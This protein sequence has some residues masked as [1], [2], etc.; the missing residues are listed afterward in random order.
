MTTA[1]QQSPVAPTLSLDD[2]SELVDALEACLSLADDNVRGTILGLVRPEIVGQIM[3]APARRADIFNIVSTCLSYPDGLRELVAAIRTFEG[4]SLPMQHLDVLV[5]LLLGSRLLTGD[6]L[7]QLK[8]ILDDPTKPAEILPRIFR[9]SYGESLAAISSENSAATRARLLSILA[10][11]PKRVGGVFPVLEFAARLA[12][13]MP[14][15]AP[16]LDVWLDEAA[17]RL[18]VST[19]EIDRLRTLAKAQESVISAP[20]PA[21]MIM[22]RPSEADANPINSDQKLFAVRAWLWPDPDNFGEQI[23]PPDDSTE[24]ED[25]HTRAQMPDVLNHLLYKECLPRLG[26]ID[27]LVIEFFLPLPL[28]NDDVEQR[29]AVTTGIDEQSPLGLAKPVVVRSFERIA[30][31]DLIGP[32][33]SPWKTKWEQLAANIQNIAVSAVLYDYVAVAQSF[34]PANQ[35]QVLRTALNQGMPIAL[36]LRTDASLPPDMGQLF[37]LLRLQCDAS[38][39]RD[40]RQLFDLLLHQC[41]LQH[42]P[43]AIW[44]KR[45]LVHQH[46]YRLKL[47]WDAQDRLPFDPL[48]TMRAKGPIKAGN[49]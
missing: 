44:R 47:L 3:R 39:P 33:W 48:A 14:E 30:S 15:I 36:W 13:C 20:R 49:Q 12:V 42:L 32:L 43:A 8:T 41:E 23:K 17:A 31:P 26:T 38:S 2:L 27:D 35:M 5:K 4:G 6:Q 28:L 18:R 24:D 10:E 19:Q 22:L 9:A 21:L 37:E 16:Q 34:D 7:R 40:L 29:W 45:Q 46:G 1:D 11:A 25:Y